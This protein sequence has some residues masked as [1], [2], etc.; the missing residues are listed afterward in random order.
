MA[1]VVI[2]IFNRQ[3][4]LC[5]LFS[6]AR[7]ETRDSVTA[8]DAV[9]YWFA[10]VAVMKSRESDQRSHFKNEVL[11]KLAHAPHAK[12]TFTTACNPQLNGAVEVVCCEVLRGTRAI[13]SELKP[14]PSAQPELTR[15]LQSVPTHS[16]SLK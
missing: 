16:P 5:Q 4:R 12:Y 8:A 14:G 1:K 15:T 7:R 3:G 2:N 11:S 10:D 9:R 6:I 13:V